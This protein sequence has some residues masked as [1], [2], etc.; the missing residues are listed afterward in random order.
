MTSRLYNP[1]LLTLLLT[2]AA[3]AQVRD[4]RGDDPRTPHP[5]SFEGIP[6]FAN[7]TTKALINVHYRIGQQF[8]V[9]VRNLQETRWE[10]FLARGEL[11]VELKDNQNLSVARDFRRIRLTR[12]TQPREG[13]ELPDVVG[14][15]SFTVPD[16]E[17]TIIFSLDDRE[18]GRQ[19]LNR[20]RKVTTRR[21][22]EQIL[23]LSF[24]MFSIVEF[25]QEKSDSIFIK[26]LNR[27]T[28]VHFDSRGG[29]TYQLYL[30]TSAS[31]NLKWTLKRQRD[32]FA[33][34]DQEWSGNQYTIMDGTLR[35]VASEGE[36][37]YAL[38]RKPN[39]PWKL[40]H[41]PLPLEQLEPGQYTLSIAINA[42][43]STYEREYSFNVVWANRPFSLT[44]LQLAVDALYHI[45]TDDEISNMQTGSLQRNLRAFHEF[46]RK[47]DRDTTTAYNEV[48]V[49]Y[50]RRVDHA[51]QRFSTITGADGYKT[52]RG[53]V[54]TLYGSPTRIDRLIPPGGVA[55]E[56]W[57]YAHIHK[58]FIFADRNRNGNLVLTATEAL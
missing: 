4:T 31:L 3:S 24:P 48:M 7:D 17:Y 20:D 50:Y 29:Y 40:L 14:A 27:G 6:L 41:I 18:S 39:T 47:R 51:I 12:A 43:G 19:V 57:T 25:H 26:P 56:V 5:V 10:E 37:T 8:F 23:E 49:E 35:L 44:N 1:L 38:V 54:F 55:T 45:A 13:E 32:P 15:F 36:V 52:D 28:H 34:R 30:P 42:D 33:Y 16:G 58:R 46:W 9:F 2:T 53:R 11:L 21:G 22:Y